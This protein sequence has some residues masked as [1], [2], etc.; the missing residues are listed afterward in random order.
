MSVETG[1]TRTLLVV[2]SN[3]ST[4][5]GLRTLGRADKARLVLA[6]DDFELENLFSVPT[7][8]TGEISVVGSEQ[9]GWEAAR[10][11]L[12]S[13]LDRASGVLLAYG[14]ARP[15]GI[16]AE[17]HREQVSWLEDQIVG[18]KLDA[19]CVGGAPRHPS[20]WQRYTYKEHPGV[21]FLDALKMSLT[22][23]RLTPT[24]S[25]ASV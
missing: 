3:P 4:T 24:P 7:Y 16:A 17:H 9:D 12:S 6:Y 5:N 20:R 2:A 11:Q 1:R 8:R 19:W 14:L 23:L 13:A 21:E 15:T 10:P 25:V 22:L 18:R